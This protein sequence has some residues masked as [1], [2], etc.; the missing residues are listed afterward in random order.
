[1][2]FIDECTIDVRAGKGGDGKAAFRREPNVPRGGPAGGDGGNGGSIILVADE[3]LGTLL[4]LRYQRT[5][6]AKHGE[7]GF[8][9]DKYGASAPDVLVRVPVGTVVYDIDSGEQLADLSAIGQ[10]FV[11]AQGGK[12]GRGNIHFATSTYQA[13]TKAEPG[14]PGQERSLRLELKL[15]ADAGLLGYPNVGKSTFIAA[16]SRARPKIADYP[17]TTLTPNLGVV[18]LPGGRSFVLAD[19]PG[20]IEGASDGLGLG[21]RF[22]RH[23]ERTRVLVHLVELSLDPERN[24]LKDYD[25]INRE[26]ERYSPELAARPQLVALSKIDVTETREAL[27]EWRAAFAK[28]GVELHAV[29][30]ATGEGVRELLEAVY[31]RVRGPIVQS[32]SADDSDDSD[33]L[34][35]D[36]TS[37]NPPAAP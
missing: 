13:P 31:A 26:L 17:F 29:S 3:Q 32:D 7:P 33:D 30:A 34:N 35:D 10:R 11:A 28:R 9:R 15:L 19:I 2:Q 36:D 21:H 14:E 4:D 18:A 6:K 22:L 8:D 25:V 23:V 16:V 24:P 1:M 12:G 37:G 5:Y 27:D 20:L